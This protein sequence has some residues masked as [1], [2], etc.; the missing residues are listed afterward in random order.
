MKGDIMA[1]GVGGQGPANI[2]KHLKGLD[3]PCRK[4]D[5]VS[6]AEHGEGP[7]TNDVLQILQKIPD[8]SYNSPRDVMKE[9]GKIE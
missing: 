7:D 9:V 2:M 5:I 3:F 4:N 6:F 8:K 1:R